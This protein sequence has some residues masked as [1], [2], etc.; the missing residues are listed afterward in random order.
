MLLIKNNLLRTV[1]ATSVL[2][3]SS[4]SQAAMTVYT[5]E[6]SFLAVVSQASTDTFND[7]SNTD[8][9]ASPVTRSVGAYGYKVSVTGTGTFFGAGTTSDPWLST[10]EAYDGI[11]FSNFTGNVSAIGGL[12]FGSDISGNYLPGRSVIVVVGDNKGTPI[13]QTITMSTTSSFLGFVSDGLITSLSVTPTQFQGRPVWPTV[14]NLTL[15]TVTAV[16]E[17]ETYAL[18]LAGLAFVGAFSRS[19]KT[20]TSA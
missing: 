13:T 15:A 6:S 18:M 2:L 11:A 14:N 17:P 9:T 19:R 20:K 8:Q 1:L 10:N 16:P 12:F 3:A 5:S 4:A 7:F